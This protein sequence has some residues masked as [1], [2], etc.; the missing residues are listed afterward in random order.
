M[1]YAICGNTVTSFSLRFNNHKSS[2]MR[3]RKGRAKGKL[4]AHYYTEGHESLMDVEIQVI[5]ITDVN[6]PNERERFWIDKIEYVLSKRIKY[7]R[8][9]NVI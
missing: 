4:Y 7:E 9:I 3:Y 1:W 5:D 2:M 8:R 6:R